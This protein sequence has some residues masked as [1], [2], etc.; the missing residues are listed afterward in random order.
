MV[1]KILARH[2]L[3]NGGQRIT[4]EVRPS[5]A[6]KWVLRLPETVERK[7]E[8]D[9]FGVYIID[10]SDGQKTVRFIIKKLAKRYQLDPVEAEQA[11][12][13]FIQILVRKGVLSLVVQER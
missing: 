1:T 10:H 7:F 11:V 4:I 13:T 3:A 12:V 6:S 9:P 8:L 5:R 2:P